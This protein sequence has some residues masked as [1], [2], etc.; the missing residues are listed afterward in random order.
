[1]YNR[2]THPLVREG[3]PEKEDRNYQ[4]VIII[5]SWAP[6]GARHQ[7]LLTDRQSQCDFD[8]DLSA[9]FPRPSEHLLECILSDSVLD[10]RELALENWV[11]FWRVVIPRRL[12]K[13]W[14]DDF[15]AIRS[16]SSYVKIFCQE[17]DSED[18]V[19]A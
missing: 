6:D 3:A 15:L 11:E 12:N 9:L 10:D 17:T 7:D 18:I 13:N 16:D 19:K 4:R 14:Q 5:W 1:M 2:Q 8:F